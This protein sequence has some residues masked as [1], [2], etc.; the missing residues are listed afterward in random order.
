MISKF[1]QQAQGLSNA[2]VANRPVWEVKAVVCTLLV[3]VANVMSIA[4]NMTTAVLTMKQFV[5][6]PCNFALSTN[7]VADM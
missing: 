1:G 2:A 6:S 4:M 7:R 3:R 5:W